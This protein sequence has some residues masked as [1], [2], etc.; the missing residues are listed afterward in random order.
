MRLLSLY[1]NYIYIVVL[2]LLFMFIIIMFVYTISS[3]GGP[4]WLGG[5]LQRPETY[6]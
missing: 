2:L 1:D 5:A 6:L 3:T 4:S